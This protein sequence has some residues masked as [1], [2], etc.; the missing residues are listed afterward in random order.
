MANALSTFL[1]VSLYGCAKNIRLR[2][3]IE[4]ILGIKRGFDLVLSH[5]FFGTRV[6]SV[7]IRFIF[8][9]KDSNLLVTRS[10]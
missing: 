10:A 1:P 9:S 4:D 7:I 3:R 8:K 5:S 6:L 2:E